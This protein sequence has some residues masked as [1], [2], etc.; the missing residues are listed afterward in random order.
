MPIYML[1][2]LRF[3]SAFRPIWVVLNSFFDVSKDGY[4]VFDLTNNEV[5]SI[6]VRVRVRVRVRIKG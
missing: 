4:S 2:N 1:S 6:R 5:Y 3:I